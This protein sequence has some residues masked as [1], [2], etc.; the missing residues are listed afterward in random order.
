MAEHIVVLHAGAV[1]EAGSH[2]E[3]LATGGIYATLFNI[4]A[5]GYRDTPVEA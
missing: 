5:R 4:Q 3:L 2:E 1:V